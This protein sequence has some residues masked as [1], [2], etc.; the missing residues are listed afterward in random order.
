MKSFTILIAIVYFESSFGLFE[1]VLKDFKLPKGFDITNV[2]DFKGFNAT[3]LDGKIFNPF[4]YDLE[5][6]FQRYS[7]WI[8]NKFY[9]NLFTFEHF[10]FFN[11]NRYN[12][13]Y[14]KEE[15]TARKKNLNNSIKA[16]AKIIIDHHKKGGKPTFT[17]GLNGLS[18]KVSTHSKCILARKVFYWKLHDSI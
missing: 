1:N 18:D 7:V 2:Y 10:F 5:D 12:K 11:Q 14:A 15:I 3:R 9:K 16:I 13:I 4:I 6:I 17:V 8:W